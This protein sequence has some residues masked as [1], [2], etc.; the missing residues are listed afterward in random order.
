[1]VSSLE[2]AGSL[3]IFLGLVLNVFGP[4]LVARLRTA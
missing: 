3:L 4:R 2:I 1:M